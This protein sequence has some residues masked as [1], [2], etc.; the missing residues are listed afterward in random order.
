MKVGI[1]G[2]PGSGKT[3]VFDL[4]TES[5]TGADPSF[6][7]N[8]P[9]I[10]AVK[11]WDPRLER[12]RDDYQPKKYT[13][14][15]LEVLDFPAVAREGHDRAGVADL[16][17]PAREVAALLIV[18]RDFINPMLADGETS[19][20]LA[21]FREVVAELVLSDLVIVERRLEKLAEKSRK[22]A[23]TDDDRRERELLGVLKERLEK[24]VSGLPEEWGPEDRRRLGGFGFLSAK[25][26][27]VVVNA[28]TGRVDESRLGE[29]RDSVGAAPLLVVAARS[30]IEILELPE[31]DRLAFLQE[32]QIEKSMRLPLIRATYQTADR[33]S[34]FTAGDKEVRAWTI[35]EGDTAPQAAGAVHTDF[36]RGFIRAEV[37]SFDDYVQYGGVKG[38]R[39]KGRYR[40][41]GREYRVADGDVIEFR[42]SV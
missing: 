2:L 11:V 25:P 41:E 3:T 7:P 18:L 37:V 24:E 13:P 26:Y 14:A 23:F 35:R 19:Q 5:S 27:V 32:Y 6:P 28:E 17:A 39:E 4:I 9:R 34:F 8:K 29:L 12:L 30:E 1:L 33:I 20:P 36:E 16:L 40:L 38:A 10:R 22:P 31:E 42:F 15:T 21:D